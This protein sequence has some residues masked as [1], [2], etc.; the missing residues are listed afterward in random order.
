MEKMIEGKD[1][2]LFIDYEFCTG[3]HTCEMA[4]KVEHKLPKGQWGIVLGKI[5]PFETAPDKWDY[6]FVPMPTD[7]CDLCAD[8]V[9]EGRWPTCVHHCQASVIEFGPVEELVKRM[10][11]PKT[12]LF[13]P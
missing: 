13:R 4:C 3:C 9:A 7:L 12:V 6:H 1:Y 2:G 11:K 8:R 5:G 10:N